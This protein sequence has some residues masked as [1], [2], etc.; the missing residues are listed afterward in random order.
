MVTT[1]PKIVEKPSVTFSKKVSSKSGVLFDNCAFLDASGSKSGGTILSPS[2]LTQSALPALIQPKGITKRVNNVEIRP[3]KTR[4][5]AIP[6]NIGSVII[7][8]E[9]PINAKAVIAIGRVL[10]S[11]E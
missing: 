4:E 7:T 2:S 11:Q 3:P 9:P 8:R 10:A 1:M 6:L 5:T